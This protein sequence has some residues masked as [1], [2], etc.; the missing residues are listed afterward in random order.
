MTAVTYQVTALTWSFF[1]G[2]GPQSAGIDQL[3]TPITLFFHVRPEKQQP[4]ITGVEICHKNAGCPW[5]TE[6]RVIRYQPFVSV[7]N[8]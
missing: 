5:F 7:Q 8:A 2:M 1:Y 3:V 4:T 6:A